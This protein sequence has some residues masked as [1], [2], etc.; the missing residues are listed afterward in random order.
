MTALSKF[1]VLLVIFLSASL[2]NAFVNQARM[3]LVIRFYASKSNSTNKPSRVPSCEPT[4][5]QM[6]TNDQMNNQMAFGHYKLKLNTAF[7]RNEKF[8]HDLLYV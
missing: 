2:G 4:N 8:Q 6:K 3:N 7:G 1:L 5:E